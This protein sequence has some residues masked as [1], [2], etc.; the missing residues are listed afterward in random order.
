MKHKRGIEL[1]APFRPA[2]YVEHNPSQYHT[3]RGMNQWEVLGAK[4]AACGHIGWLDKD[5][6]LRTF[7]DMYLMNLRN[8]LRCEC[9]SSAGNVVL[10]GNLPR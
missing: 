9:G 5:A 6:I 3:I 4:C 2:H 1:T 8:R 7:G 10:I